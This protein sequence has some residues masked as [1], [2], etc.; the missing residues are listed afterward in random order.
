MGFLTGTSLHYVF[1]FL[2][3]ALRIGSLSEEERGLKTITKFREERKYR[4]KLPVSSTEDQSFKSK[5]SFAGL[6]V[7]NEVEQNRVGG[8]YKRAEEAHARAE[9]KA[10]K[11]LYLE[12]GNGEGER[13]MERGRRESDG[14]CGRKVFMT[15]TILEED[16]SSDVGF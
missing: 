1:N 11:N 8:A 2:I 10:K 5:G 16:D 3:S 12:R 7:G 15:G 6:A 9:R 13:G 14:M 4:R